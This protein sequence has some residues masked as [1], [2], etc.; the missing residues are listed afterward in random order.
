MSELIVDSF[1]GGGGASLGIE[2]AIGRS[3]DIAIN[4]DPEAVAMHAAN[5][6]ETRHYCESVWRVDPVEATGGRPVGLLWASPDCKHFSKAK[7]AA[8]LDRNIRGLAWIVLRWAA[9][10]RPRV[11]VVENVEEFRTWGPLKGGKPVAALKGATFERWLS[12]LR[13]LGY[14]VEWRELRACDYGAPTI[15]KRLFIVA[16]RDGLPIRW[17]EPSHGPGRPLPWRTAAECIDWSIPCPSIFGRKRPLAEATL[18]RIARG[19]RRFVLEAPQPFIVPIT[20]TGDSRVHGLEE[21]LRTVTAAH[22]GEHALISPFLVPRYGEREGQDPRCLPADAPMP[23]VVPT[24]NGAGLVAAFLAQH[25]GGMVGHAASEPVSTI[26]GKGSTQQLVAAYLAQHNGERTGRDAGE[27]LSTIVHRGTQQQVVAAVLSHQYG[28]ATNGGQGD[29]RLP[30]KTITTGGHHALVAAFLTQYNGA[31]LGREPELPLGTQS[32]RDRFGAVTVTIAGEPWTI[33]DIGMR[34]LVPRELFRAQGFPDS[35]VV[36]APFEGRRLTKTAQT[37]M[38]GN[39]VCPPIARAIVEANCGE[40]AAAA[41][42]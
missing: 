40:L 36:D 11:I 1:A 33:V 31:A 2:M 5:H 9:R 39:S 18:R 34:M 24:G 14:R 4:H 29:P 17:P 13:D 8:L 26:V 7:G 3:P 35:Y 41:A 6:P 16:R 21:P 10:A 38:C 42:A 22:R 28:S 15:R 23:T 27:P 32:T 25:N 19:V 37:R 12:Q 20:H 30:I